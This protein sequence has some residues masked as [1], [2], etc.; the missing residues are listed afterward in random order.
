MIASYHGFFRLPVLVFELTPWSALVGFAI[1]FAAASLGVV[2]ALRNVVALAPAVAMRPAAPRRFRRSWIEGLLSAKA[3]TPRRVLA[4]RNFAGR[5]LRSAFT[6]VGIALAVPM[7]VL[8][9]FWR[10]AI[11]QMIE[12]QFNLVERGN[13][14]VTFPHPLNRTVVGDL[15]REP[16]VLVAEGS[17]I[18]PGSPAR[19]ASQLSDV[20][21]R[22]AVQRWT[23]A[24]AR[25]RAAS[26]RRAAGRHHAHP[27]AGRADPGRPRRD[28]DDRSHGGPAP[29]DRPAGQRHRRRGDRDV[30]LHGDRHAQPA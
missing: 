23:A 10:D 17:A 26:D 19:G 22:L 28:R 16:G 25:C 3:L 1:S 29:Q 14:M 30:L 18:C 11:D 13:V 24:A 9:L 6:I 21:D 27:P 20:G 8:G 4:I 15:A 5:P 7:V 12:V 2:T